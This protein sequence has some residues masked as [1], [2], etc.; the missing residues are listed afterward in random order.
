LQD[1]ADAQKKADMDAGGLGD[2]PAPRNAPASTHDDEIMN[3][4]HPKQ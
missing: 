3:L 2:N 1:A 4:L